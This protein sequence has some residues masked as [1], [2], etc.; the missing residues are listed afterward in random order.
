MIKHRA[1][2]CGAAF[3]V[4]TAACERKTPGSSTDG[5]PSG[6]ESLVAVV[7]APV[8]HLGFATRVPKDADLFIAG[9]HAN[10]IIAGVVKGVVN[11]EEMSDE[12]RKEFEDVMS[13]LG[14]EAF[15][16]VG[17]G[18]GGQLEMLGKTYQEMSASWAG[19]AVGSMLDLL[20]KQGAQP[21]ISKLGEGLS[22]DLLDKWLDAFEKDSKLRIPSILMGW[23][24]GPEKQSECRDAVEKA[25]GEMI[26]GAKEA[27][28]VTFDAHGASMAGFEIS[29]REAF[30]EM[31]AEARE[32]LAKNEKTSDLFEQIPPE[33]MERL[34]AAM[35]NMRLTLAS[36][37]VD[38]RVVIYMGNGKEGFQ[39]ADAPADSL[40]GVDDLTWTSEFADKRIV[41]VM[42]L[43]ESIIRSVLPLMD[44]SKY[45]DAVSQAIR[46][47]VREERLLRELLTSLAVTERDLAH[48]DASA[49]SAIGFED[50]GFRIE[51]RGGWPDPSLDYTTPLSMTDAAASQSPAIRAHW[52]QQRGRND[53]A[54]KR[55]EHYGHLIDTVIGEFAAAENSMLAMVPEGVLERITKEMVAINHSYRNEFREGIGD[56]I[57][58]VADFQGEV[59]PVPGISE[60][61]VKTAKAPRFILARPV[62]DRAKLNAAGKSL[63]ASWRSLTAWASEQSGENLPLIVPQSIESGGLTTWYPPL[64][65]IGG[66]FMPGVTLNDDLWMMGTSRS[67]AGGFAKSMAGTGKGGGTGMIVEIDFAP[68][69]TW[70]ADIYQ[71]NETA[72]MD[73]T[74][75]APDEMKELA[76]KENLERVHSFMSR[77][78]GLSYRKWMADGKP[79]T[80][81]HLRM[82]PEN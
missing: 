75:E 47:P 51:S 2:A 16:V 68:V 1:L 5:K 76:K 21:D 46:P 62:R 40:A 80:S 29:G 52:I 70:F 78:K 19:F 27:A 30:S 74:E 56:E 39:L 23:K 57:A 37:M 6:V 58:F 71:R 41:G 82:S 38:E 65:F 59:P 79:R 4:F 26:A 10:E 42:Y 3:L 69:K 66:D 34:L 7:K 13:Y 81:M 14:D 33:R 9:Y 18:A 15:M 73:L 77:L 60:E 55:I 35:E 12:N 45:W 72:A 28:P 63:V 64:P 11:K 36:G 53:L 61:T 25:L 54:W 49:W 24:P 43:S 22:D 20:G 8:T 67:L 48:R 32:E 50:N 17:A 44:S 31:I